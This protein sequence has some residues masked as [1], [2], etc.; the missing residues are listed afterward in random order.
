MIGKGFARLRERMIDPLLT[1]LTIMLAVLKFVVGPLQA[2]GV[3]E[4]HF[5]G[6]AFGLLLLGAVFVVSGS[7]VAV[8]AS[9]PV[10]NRIGCGRNC[11]AM[12]SAV[13]AR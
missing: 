8:V 3:V 9:Y 1:A 5:F 4:A 6:I 11:S 13:G 12:A 2:A 10:L 7:G